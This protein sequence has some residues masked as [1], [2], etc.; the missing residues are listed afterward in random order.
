MQI[1]FANVFGTAFFV[2]YPEIISLKNYLRE[3]VTLLL[4]VMDNSF[5]SL[6]Y[7]I[8]VVYVFVIHADGE[9]M[10]L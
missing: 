9:M 4:K 10:S 2:S 8:R 1:T 3:F 6:F 5:F 7:R